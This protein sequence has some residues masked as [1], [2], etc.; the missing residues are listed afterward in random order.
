VTILLRILY[1]LIFVRVMAPPGICLCKL[2]APLA[3]SLS[4][5]P[6]PAQPAEPDNDH[7]PGCPASPLA[8][9]MGLRAPQLTAP[10]P[11]LSLETPP[12]P[13]DLSEHI[14][15]AVLE[16]SFIAAARPTLVDTS[17]LLLI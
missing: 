6:V 17:C 10:L 12:A 3:Y 11:D 15:A 16:D 13:P 8:A 14:A 1:L 9:A 7:E 5:Q 2:T 4:G